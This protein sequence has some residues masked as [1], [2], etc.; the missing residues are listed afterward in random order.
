MI[1][2]NPVHT[3]STGTTSPLQVPTPSGHC[4]VTLLTTARGLMGT[5]R[6]WP[7]VLCLTSQV[8]PQAANTEVGQVLLLSWIFPFDV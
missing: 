1:P 7:V 8:G 4:S 2:S 6:K 3:A 5:I